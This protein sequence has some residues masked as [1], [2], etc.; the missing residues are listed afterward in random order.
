VLLGTYA[1]YLV[2]QLY[3]HHDMFSEVEKEPGGCR[4]GRKAQGAAGAA[5]GAPCSRRSLCRSAGSC[6]PHHRPRAQ[7]P[8]S[9]AASLP[10][11]RL[12]AGDDAA[13]DASE[14]EEP[15][16][17]VPC[18]VVMLAVITLIVATCSEFLT[19]S[20][21][22]VADTLNVSQGFIGMIVLPIAGNACEHITAVVVRGA[23]AR[24]VPP[25]GAMLWLDRACC[26]E[27][28]LR[29]WQRRAHAAQRPHNSNRCRRR[30]AT[31]TKAT[32]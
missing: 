14:A 16:L 4:A 24:A 30:I 28:S 17:S 12:P 26:R 13:S 25:A 6:C 22:E 15:R 7:R 29:R 10:P 32:T 31:T 1:C 19:G 8:H 23:A 11:A 3:T 18:A 21:E 2:F 27:R 20:I 5:G 9:A